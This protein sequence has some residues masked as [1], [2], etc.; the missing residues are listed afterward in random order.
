MNNHRQLA[1]AAYLVAAV[2]FVFPVFDSGIS[3]SPWNMGSAQW[4]FGAVG[5]LSNTLMI[6]ALGAFIAVAT[7][8]TTKQ[9]RVRRVLGYSCWVIAV[10]LLASIAA[11]ALDAVQARPQIRQDMMLS[12]QLASFTAEVK[13]LVGALSF[14]LFGRGCR[15]EGSA[16]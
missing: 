16:R 5:L 15:F 8:V 3:L 10:V 2:L 11:F 9:D 6:V 4:R 7:A 13:L 12:Y 14:A 1:P